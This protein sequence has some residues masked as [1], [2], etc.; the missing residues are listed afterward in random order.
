MISRI[1][2]LIMV[3]LAGLFLLFVVF[4]LPDMAYGQ[5]TTPEGVPPIVGAP[6]PEGLPPV[7]KITAGIYI[8]DIQSIDLR[9]HSYVVDFFLWFRW[10]D[11]DFDPL[12][13]YEI[14]NTFEP[15]AHV[16]IP[17]YDAPQAQPDGSFYT[18]VRRQG[19][20][21]TKFNVTNYP[22][23]RQKL[24]IHLEDTELTSRELV[25][26]RDAKPLTLNPDIALPG[27]KILPPQVIVRDKP[28]A[29]NFG[30][31]SEPEEAPYSRISF[32]IPIER[33][34]FSGLVKTFLPVFLIIA[35]AAL[36][37]FL[38]PAHV[39]ARIGLS[40]TALLTL[41]ATQFTAAGSLP[42]VAYLTM[43]D[44]IY[45]SSY[46]FILVVIGLVVRATRIDDFGKITKMTPSMALARGGAI[47]AFS[48]TS[49]Y[50]LVI[51]MIVTFHLI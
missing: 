24:A 48:I 7:Q 20:F 10:R 30:D 44:Q 11:P 39:D 18:I 50:L 9:S 38:D 5:E 4:I 16:E 35:G 42:E 27:F 49:I 43:L 37:L 31:L 26:Q 41:V 3:L 15:D 28:Y 22:F 19:A 34:A 2:R 51:L 6:A 14:M 23:D 32:E 8:N 12:Q 13:S 1:L 36:A 47:S 40:I 46:L 17:L 25:F 45:I 21:S 33:P 29:T